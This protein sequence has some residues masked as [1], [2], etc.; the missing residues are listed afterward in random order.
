MAWKDE[1]WRRRIAVTVDVTA[2]GPTVGCSFSLA[3][4]PD[5]FWDAPGLD[6]S[7][8]DLRVYGPDGT[9]AVAFNL[10]SFNKTSRTG[11]VTVDDFTFDAAAMSTLW[12]DYDHSGSPS[13]GSTSVSPSVTRTAYPT[14][15]PHPRMNVIQVR[16]EHLGRD[17]P[18]T[19]IQKM[20][21]EVLH[22]WWDWSAAL[23]KQGEKNAG[24]V[25]LEEVAWA[26]PDSLDNAGASQAGMKAVTD[27]RILYPGLVRTTVKAGSSGNKYVASCQIGTTEGRVLEYRVLVRVKNTLP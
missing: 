16:L 10:A 27:T 3:G 1:L 24:H 12:L 20:T 8:N 19:Q 11:T 25:S 17:T 23:L 4:L 5:K 7:G 18:S 15:G 14:Q 2:A 13:S 6:A 22:L 26:I 21:S 9:T